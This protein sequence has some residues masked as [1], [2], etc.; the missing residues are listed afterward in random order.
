M[1]LNMFRNCLTVIQFPYELELFGAE[2]ILIVVYCHYMYDEK[3]ENKRINHEVADL[4][5]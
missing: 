1:S 5:Y 4:L 2:T 3:F